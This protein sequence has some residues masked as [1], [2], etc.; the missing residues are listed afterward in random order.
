MIDLFDLAIARKIGG[1]DS[2]GS[3]LQNKSLNITENGSQTITPDTGYDGLSRVDVSV[4]VSGGGSSAPTVGF[5]PSEWDADGYI[6]NGTWY[7]K[8]I[9]A[10]AFRRDLSVA[11]GSWSLTNITLPDDLDYIDNYAFFYCKDLSLTTL[12]DT[13]RCINA[14]AF[15]NCTSLQLEKLP[16]SLEV[17]GS[18]AFNGCASLALTSIDNITR[19]SYL[20]STVF[21]GCTSLQIS[22]IPAQITSIEAFA[23]NGCTGLTQIT[24][25]GTPATIHANAFK[26]C[27][28]LT[29]INV[30]WAEG[31]VANAPWGA[32]NA[33]INYGVTE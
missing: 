5:V 16:D 19:V 3:V 8:N 21:S 10:G 4:N 13:V 15:Y 33:T 26:N 2:P 32:F 24:F 17:L 30:P 31:E 12:P 25:K 11:Q 23:F 28:N 9:P 29:V 27:S 20:Q 14:S 18:K 7:G 6:T 22:A 1:G